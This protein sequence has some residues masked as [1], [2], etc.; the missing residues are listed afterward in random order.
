[1]I[2]VAKPIDPVI[3]ALGE[4][5]NHAN[6]FRRF[7]YTQSTE[8]TNGTLIYNLMTRELL[9]LDTNE[10][11]DYEKMDINSATVK[12]LIKKW[13]IVPQK[14][15]DYKLFKQTDQIM[16]LLAEAS[17]NK[18]LHRF[19]I[20]PTLDC[21]ARCFY[22][23][24]LSCKRTTMT[25]KTANDVAEF[26]IKKSRGKK[27]HI[28]WF[29]G[30]P[31]YNLSAIDTISSKLSESDIIYDSEMVSNGYLFDEKI[32]KTAIK[33]W[34]LNLI[35]ITLD[36]TENVYNRTKAYIYKNVESPFKRVINNITMLLNAGIFVKIRLNMDIYNCDDLRQ[37]AV[38]LLDTFREYNN[39]YIYIS[40]LFEKTGKSG[41]FRSISDKDKLNQKFR[42]IERIIDEYGKL[43]KYDLSLYRSITQCMADNNTCT[44][45][46]PGGE[47][48]KC[49]HYT[50]DNYY[51][52]IYSD[53]IDTFYINK[54]KERVDYGDK[55]HNCPLL[56]KCIHLKACPNAQSGCDDYDR[57]LNI[58]YLKEQMITSYERFK[59]TEKKKS[60]GSDNGIDYSMC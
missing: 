14:Y 32:I 24:E 2:E 35:Q 25:E 16:R 56:P 21:N 55:C 57:E 4:Q 48:G 60:S 6:E 17:N 42:E 27:V 29:G 28:M 22:C 51:G 15:D 41:T 23:F 54:F 53:K 26:I 30:E 38:F 7:L 58:R 43:R 50:D 9:F 11:Y 47:L 18:P 44:T 5:T 10:T 20:Y 33:L 1:M 34:K 12:V 31:L 36:G 8:V 39:F 13:F 40:L 52:S 37:L 3:K 59:K 46:L 49:E 45:I 19:I